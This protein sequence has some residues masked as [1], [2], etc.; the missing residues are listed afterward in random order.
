MSRKTIAVAI[1]LVTAAWLIFMLP[2][3][4]A[5][6]Q[7][8]M[9]ALVVNLENPHPVV[10]TVS[11]EGTIR[12]ADTVR[13]H[14]VIVSSARRDEP[15]RWTDAGVVDTSGFTHLAL[16]VQGYVKGRVNQPGVIGVIL[17]PEEEPIIQALSEGQIHLP[18]EVTADA[19]PGVISYF[20]ASEPRLPIAFPQ[21]RVWLY[22]TTEESAAANVFLYLTN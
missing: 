10:G 20:S 6:S 14:D 15:P 11:V 17:I 3:G 18:L 7:E 12:H 4:V 21:Y 9:R 2:S 8:V 19:T 16:S 1:A 5:R 22:N 13:V